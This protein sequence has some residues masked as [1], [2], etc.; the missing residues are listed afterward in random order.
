VLGRER[1][2]V[3]ALASTLVGGQSEADTAKRKHQHAPRHVD[4]VQSNVGRPTRGG[5]HG[6]RNR[7]LEEAIRLGFHQALQIG[8]QQRSPN[9]Q[10]AK[11]CPPRLSTQE[12]IHREQSG[13]EHDRCF[14]ACGIP[15]ADFPVE[16]DVGRRSEGAQCNGPRAKNG[17]RARSKEG[18]C[19][20][21]LAYITVAVCTVV[22][23]PGPTPG[24]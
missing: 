2:L 16:G 14:W 10:Y 11:T 5:F 20:D 3:C 13:R 1:Y 8:P 18:T 21:G 19:Q 22:I 9:Q 23:G 15:V 17:E 12:Q 7:T 4:E 6:G 24:S